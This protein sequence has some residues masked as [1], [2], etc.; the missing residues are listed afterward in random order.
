MPPLQRTSRL[1]LSALSTA[2]L[3]VAAVLVFTIDKPQSSWAIFVTM[4]QILLPFAATLSVVWLVSAVIRHR[5][6]LR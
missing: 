3:L 4:G 1:V 5:F 6:D 2:A